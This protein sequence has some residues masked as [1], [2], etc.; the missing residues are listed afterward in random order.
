[1]GRIEHTLV[2]EG[3]ASSPTDLRPPPAQTS[4]HT[5]VTNVS[6]H[7]KVGAPSRTSARWNLADGKAARTTERYELPQP[8][9][10]PGEV[11]RGGLGSNLCDASSL[12]LP[13]ALH[14]SLKGLVK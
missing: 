13:L 1:M 14:E 7:S 3:R 12:A 10:L 6:S 11:V 2:D 9:L 5:K 4:Y 8:V